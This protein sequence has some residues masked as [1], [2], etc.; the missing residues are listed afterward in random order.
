M[1]RTINPISM[2]AEVFP[3]QHATT[4]QCIPSFMFCLY[5]VVFAIQI[6]IY[7]A[8][9]TQW[10]RWGIRKPIFMLSP[11]RHIQG[12]ESPHSEYLSRKNDL[13][14][15]V[16]VFPQTHR[17]FCTFG[18]EETSESG[19]SFSRFW[20]IMHMKC[21]ALLYPGLEFATYCIYSIFVLHE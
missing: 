17:L 21:R 15:I 11:M 8:S 9:Q 5:S 2:A 14:S 7:R 18:P 10:P 20:K 19:G 6:S 12:N 3:I 4:I 13:I 1:P 16:T